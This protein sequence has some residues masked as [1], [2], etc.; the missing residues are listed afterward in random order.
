MM[1]AQILHTPNSLLYVHVCLQIE[2]GHTSREPGFLSDF[3]DSKVFKSHPLFSIRHDA[4]QLQLYYDDIEVC[5]PIGSHRKVH[6][7]GMYSF[8]EIVL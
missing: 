1:H 8:I 2:R 4:L 3:C 6:K 7:L 5:N